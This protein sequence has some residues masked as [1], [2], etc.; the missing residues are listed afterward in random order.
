MGRRKLKHWIS[1]HWRLNSSNWL[2]K[3]KMCRTPEDMQTTTMVLG[4]P[5]L[6]PNVQH[7][8][9]RP[10]VA[11]IHLSWT[12]GNTTL[13]NKKESYFWQ[14]GVQFHNALTELFH[15]LRQQ[16]ISVGNAIVQIWHFVESESAENSSF[17]FVTASIIAERDEIYS[18]QVLVVE[19]LRQ[20]LAKTQL[21]L[22]QSKLKVITVR[23]YY[24]HNSFAMITL[25]MLLITDI[26]GIAN[27]YLVR[28]VIKYFGLR[29][30]TPL[31]E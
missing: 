25:S 10:P 17:A 21:Q 11:E 23:K 28:W 12:Q 9:Q 27:T 31:K 26:A 20:T 1:L 2:T 22:T 3:S 18:L 6:N 8:M 30:I 29:S 4:I 7:I 19:M 16:L 15:V 13:T 5:V 24:A 14:I